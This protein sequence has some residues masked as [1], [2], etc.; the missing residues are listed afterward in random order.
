MEGAEP[1]TTRPLNYDLLCSSSVYEQSEKYNKLI[2]HFESA[3][4]SHFVAHT[5]A[6]EHMVLK[7]GQVIDHCR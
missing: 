3:G 5:K 7:R 2:T 6:V 4:L 1:W